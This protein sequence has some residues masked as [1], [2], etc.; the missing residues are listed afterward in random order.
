MTKMQKCKKIKALYAVDYR[1][2]VKI[3][4]LTSIRHYFYPTVLFELKSKK[5]RLLKRKAIFFA[6]IIMLCTHVKHTYILLNL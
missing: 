1:C 3:F 2:N 6:G 5:R 4:S